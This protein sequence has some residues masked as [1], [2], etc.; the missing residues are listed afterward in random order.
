[1]NDETHRK[2]DCSKF[3]SF[4]DLTLCFCHSR[5]NVSPF[6]VFLL[7]FPILSKTDTVQIK[8]AARVV[9]FLHRLPDSPSA[10]QETPYL[11]TH[12]CPSLLILHSGSLGA[13]ARASGLGVKAGFHPGRVTSS[14][15]G[16]AERQTTIHSRTCG[17]L[18]LPVSPACMSSDCGRNCHTVVTCRHHAARHR[19]GV[20][21][22]ALCLR[23]DGANRCTA[24]LPRAAR[25][26]SRES[27]LHVASFSVTDFSSVRATLTP[28]RCCRFLVIYTTVVRQS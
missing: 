13:G 8:H 25:R 19:V 24:V 3:S 12:V 17:L 14:S 15:R 7:H 18:E 26:S 23:G 20:K 21:H 4:K 28:A 27:P 6:W 11:Q 22:A 16:H 10:R 1:M 5:I 9:S 2:D